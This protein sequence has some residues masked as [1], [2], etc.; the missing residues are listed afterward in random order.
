MSNEF[1]SSIEYIVCSKENKREKSGG[2]I[3]QTRKKSGSD[4]SAP[5]KKNNTILE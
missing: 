3:Y 2:L 4:E 5:Y 1:V